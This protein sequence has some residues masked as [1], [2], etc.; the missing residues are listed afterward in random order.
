M[1]RYK[2]KKIK[3]N[4]FGNKNKKLVCMDINFGNEKIAILGLGFATNFGSKK[5]SE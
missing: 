5:S 3:I 1:V 4:L 2:K